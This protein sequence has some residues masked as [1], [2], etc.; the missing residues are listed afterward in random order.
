MTSTWVPGAPAPGKLA[1]LGELPVTDIVKSEAT[2]V[3]PSSLRTFLITIS[4]AETSLF[5]IVQVFV[6]FATTATVSVATPSQTIE[7]CA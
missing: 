3:P 5:V 6:A 4:F 1:G 2:L 7:V